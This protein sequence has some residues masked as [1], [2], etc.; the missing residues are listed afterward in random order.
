[1]A[2]LNLRVIR[3]RPDGSE[4]RSGSWPPALWV[5]VL[6]ADALAIAAFFKAVF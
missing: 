2:K 4:I 5:A 3:H 1:M 6:A